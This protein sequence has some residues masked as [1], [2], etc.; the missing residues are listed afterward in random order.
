[1]AYQ[2]TARDNYIL[3][4]VQTATPQ[5]LQLMLVEAA[6]KNVHRTKKAWSEDKIDVGLESLMKAQ[7][8]IAA[9]LSSLDKEGNP[10]IARQLASIYLFIFRRLAEAGMTYK[11]EN[12]DDA[13]RVLNSEKETWKQV[14]EKFGASVGQGNTGQAV[15][16]TASGSV[17]FISKTNGEVSKDNIGK[18]QILV[19]PSAAVVPPPKGSGAFSKPGGFASGGNG[20]TETK[21]GIQISTSLASPKKPETAPPKP[22]TGNSWE[23]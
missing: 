1:M 16:K 15:S 9:I 20:T 12:L 2:N 5:K 7:D 22:N 4:E 23:V 13:L 11:Q 6:I 10:E 8:I 19:S 18:T 14:C 17:E 3:A 21:A